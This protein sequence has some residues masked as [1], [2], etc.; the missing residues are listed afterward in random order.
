MIN[1]NLQYCSESLLNE[2]I[3]ADLFDFERLNDLSN[4][5]Y[6]MKHLATP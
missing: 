1:L 2:L 3:L 5:L 4:A 6:K